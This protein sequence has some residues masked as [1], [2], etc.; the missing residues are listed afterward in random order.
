MGVMM[1]YKE[2][3][4]TRRWAGVLLLWVVLVAGVGLY[5][6]MGLLLHDL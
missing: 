1:D 4:E 3:A 2:Q 6:F 5:V